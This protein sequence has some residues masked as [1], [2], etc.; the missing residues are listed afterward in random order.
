MESFFSFLSILG[1]MGFIMYV[2]LSDVIG[3]PSVGR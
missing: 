1:D 2:K 3:S